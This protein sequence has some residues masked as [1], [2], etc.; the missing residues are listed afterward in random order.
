MVVQRIRNAQVAGSNPAI[1]SK[2]PHNHALFSVWLLLYPNKEFWKWYFGTYKIYFA[3]WYFFRELHY[4]QYCG[5]YLALIN[6]K[7]M[8]S[9]FLPTALALLCRMI[10][11]CFFKDYIIKRLGCHFICHSENVWINITRIQHLKRT[12]NRI[13]F[14]NRLF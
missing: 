3:L 9:G 8:R 11:A 14:S 12:H 2:K 13:I 5:T 6:E 1:S 10:F 4:L 7:T